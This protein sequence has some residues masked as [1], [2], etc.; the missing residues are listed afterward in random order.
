MFRVT[1]LTSMDDRQLNKWIRRLVLILVAGTVLFAGFYF[2]DRWR[3]P[4]TPIV[5]RRVSA[6]EQAVR[7]NPEDIVARGQLADT[8]VAK[9][10]Y[11]EALVQYNAILETGKADEQAQYGRA[12]AY[13]GLEQLD[14]AA[15]DY[16]GVVEIAKGGEMANVDPMLQACYYSLGDIA[17]KPGEADGGDP[18]PR[19]GPRDQALR[20]GCALPDRDGVHRDG[21]DR[22]G[23]D[24]PA[25]GRRLRADR[26]ERALRGA[27]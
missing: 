3:A 7:D 26:L 27:R 21:R 14:L 6:L 25:R 20:C 4:A 19:E 2:L 5:D 22:Q 16:Q 12:G 24:G 15:R 18:P 8:Y 9:G 11:E 23:R 13:M 10:Q 17:L 1:S